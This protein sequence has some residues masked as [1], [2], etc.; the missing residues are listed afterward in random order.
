MSSETAAVGNRAAGSEGGGGASMALGT[1]QLSW[2][3]KGGDAPPA[4]ST[5]SS[6][7]VREA[8]TESG[9]GKGKV[10]PESMV[11]LGF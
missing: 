7:E 1:L 8:G 4:S 11:G 6:T 2:A 5:V 3:R 9:G 10:S